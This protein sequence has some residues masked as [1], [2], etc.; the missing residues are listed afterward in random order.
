MWQVGLALLTLESVGVRTG[1]AT[2][3]PRAAG[4]RTAQVVSHS[5]PWGPMSDK[6]GGSGSR[7]GT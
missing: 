6:S 7:C 4:Y 3:R 5:N 1:Q 2:E